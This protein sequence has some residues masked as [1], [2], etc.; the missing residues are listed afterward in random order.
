MNLGRELGNAVCR[1]GWELGAR[2]RPLVHVVGDSHVKSFAWLSGCVVRHLGAATAYKLCDPHSSTRSR[3]KLFGELRRFSGERHAFILAFGEIDCRVHIYEQHVK[4]NGAVSMETLMD[5]T[6][7]RYGV[8]M[9]EITAMGVKFVVLGPP[10]ATKQPNVYRRPVY[11]TPDVHKF[12]YSE[13]N[14][15]LRDYCGR[16]G[17]R[18]IDIQSQTGGADG[19]SRPEYAADDVHLNRSAARIALRLAEEAFES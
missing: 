3:E 11:A 14:R 13:F 2:R 9:K 4:G 16:N 5:E 18:Y 15:R 19:F 1:L 12:I 7:A 6:I 10:P 17:H 8:V